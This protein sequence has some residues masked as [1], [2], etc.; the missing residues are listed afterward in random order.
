MPATPVPPGLTAALQLRHPMVHV[1]G[2]DAG[3][4]VEAIGSN[5]A[6]LQ[7]PVIAGP[8]AGFLQGDVL[9]SEQVHGEARVEHLAA[10]PIRRHLL[11]PLVGVLPTRVGLKEPAHLPL[12]KHRHL[13]FEGGWQLLS[14]K[15]G[16]SMM[17]ESAEISSSSPRRHGFTS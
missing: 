3:H 15:C 16:S 6:I 4:T 7:D 10:Y 14:Q 1:V 2:A 9:E 5:R 12:G 11:H 13:V 17:C 8:E